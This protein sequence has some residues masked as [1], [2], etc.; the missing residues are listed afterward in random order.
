MH[1]M[2]SFGNGI[3]MHGGFDGGNVLGDTWIF[4]MNG[5]YNWSPL[6]NAAIATSERP[7]GRILHQITGMGGQKL[8]L[9]GGQTS[10]VTQ[11]VYPKDTWIFYRQESVTECGNKPECFTWKKLDVNGPDPRA[12]HAMFFIDDNVIM[13][14]GKI[15]QIMTGAPVQMVANDV[16]KFNIGEK[17]RIK[18]FYVFH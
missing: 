8:L 11:D 12:R 1:A 7:M 14:G 3:V 2:A 13:Y 16:W 18:F 17:I 5:N 9:F 4:S 6:D 10:T 15:Q